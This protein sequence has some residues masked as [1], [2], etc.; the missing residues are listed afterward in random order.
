METEPF[1]GIW[2]YRSF[3]NN[4]D[5]NVEFNELRFGAGTLRLYSPSFGHLA[6]TL[7]GTGWEL[8][9]NGAVAY[10]N[11]FACRFQGVGEIGGEAWV[12]DYTGCLTPIWPHG[13]DQVPAITGSVIRTVAHS[14]GQAPAGFVASFIAAR[15]QAA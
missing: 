4:P 3:V 13:V 11:P 14:N 1:T 12:Y 15:S 6:G 7:G 10:G 9:L 2:S 8:T 5:L